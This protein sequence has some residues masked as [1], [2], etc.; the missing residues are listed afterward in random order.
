MSESIEKP[1]EKMLGPIFSDIG[2]EWVEPGSP[3]HLSMIHSHLRGRMKQ[4]TVTRGIEENV[5]NIDNN[6]AE[7]SSGN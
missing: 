6:I 4:T 1:A 3:E 5:E 2:A 7:Q